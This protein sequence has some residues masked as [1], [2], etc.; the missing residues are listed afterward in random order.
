VDERQTRQGAPD[1]FRVDY[2]HTRPFTDESAV[3]LRRSVELRKK[4]EDLLRRAREVRQ[5]LRSR[6][7][8]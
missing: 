4:S 1:P 5:R 7:Q 3:L 6:D 2:R 8:L